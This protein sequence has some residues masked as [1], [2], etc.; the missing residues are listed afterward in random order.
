MT[1]CVVV[2]DVGL[3]GTVVGV[4]GGSGVTVGSVAVLVAGGGSGMTVGLGSE[5]H[6]TSASAKTPSNHKAVTRRID[7]FN[8]L[9]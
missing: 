2:A 5:P 7:E 9:S 4:G 6:A 8:Q 3:G 1:A